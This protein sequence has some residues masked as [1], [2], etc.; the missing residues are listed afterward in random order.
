MKKLHITLY[1]LTSI[2]ILSYNA[3]TFSYKKLLSAFGGT[4]Y[5]ERIEKEYPIDE[6]KKLLIE[7]NIGNITIKSDWS[8]KSIGLIASIHKKHD[9]EL[10]DIIED[11]TNPKLLALRT[12]HSD[13]KSKAIVNYTLIVPENIKLQLNTKKGNIVVHNTHGITMATTD[14]GNIRLHNMHNKTRATTMQSGSISCSSCDGPLQATT[15]RGNV[16]ISDARNSITTQTNQGKIT[17]KCNDFPDNCTINAASTWGNIILYLPSDCNANLQAATKKGT[18]VC[19]HFITLRPQTTKLNN[20]AWNKFRRTIDGT[21][22]DG[23]TPIHVSSV[24][25][26]IRIMT[27]KRS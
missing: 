20:N 9:N 18:C 15:N 21:I 2:M 23:R 4:P 3:T 13:A 10:I 25:S 12:A 26:N 19:E 1:T 27:N 24:S 8:K 5:Q 22:G 16:T 11:T 6:Q 17:V 7:N 14:N